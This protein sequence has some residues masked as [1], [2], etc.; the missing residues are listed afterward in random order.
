MSFGDSENARTDETSEFACLLYGIDSLYVGYNLDRLESVLDFDE[1]AFLKE[2]AS[3]SR[4]MK[5]AE[6]TI[7]TE[8]FIVQPRGNYPYTW[9]LTNS[10]FTISL[11]ENMSPNTYVQFRSE[12][13]WTDGVE[14]LEERLR[15]WFKSAGMSLYQSEKVSRVDWS[16][17]FKVSEPDF[18]KEHFASRC[19]KFSMHGGSNRIQTIQLGKG[20]TV[21]RLY[22][23]V[24]EIEEV[25]K[26]AW[27]YRLWN[28][29][30]DVW[31]LEFQIRGQ[32]LKESG[33]RSLADL[34][35]YQWDLLRELAT[36]HT[37]LL[38]PTGDTNKSRW[39]LHPIWVELQRLIE[40]APQT[41]LA[42]DVWSSDAIH[43]RIEQLAASVAGQMKALAAMK[44]VLWPG[45]DVPT[46]EETCDWLEDWQHYQNADSTW[47][48]DVR[49]KVQALEFER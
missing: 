23:K 42:Q 30:R 13:L 17:D 37:R 36:N 10:A 22:D 34:A 24:A 3:R 21:I 11:S 32:R 15:S 28:R 27:F 49:T 39:P 48:T 43:I 35:D 31:R 19:Q 44:H 14:S 20:D 41:G 5:K 29:D 18:H 12:A 7:G 4:G 16:F 26:K 9:A 33:I 6:I 47:N 45:E 25:S 2:K 46:I 40:S 1:L 38:Q 8:T